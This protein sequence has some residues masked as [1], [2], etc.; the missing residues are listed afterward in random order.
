LGTRSLSYGLF[1]APDIATDAQSPAGDVQA[2]LALAKALDPTGKALP[3]WR[4]NNTKKWC[5]EWLADRGCNTQQGVVTQ[6]D[7]SQAGL[8]AAAPLQGTLP[9]QLP[10]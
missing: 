9:Q 4:A 10:Q 5:K 7:I 3:K 8:S 6:L 1:L 2:L